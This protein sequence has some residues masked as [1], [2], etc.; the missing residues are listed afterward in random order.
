MTSITKIIKTLHRNRTKRGGLDYLLGLLNYSGYWS[1]FSSSSPKVLDCVCV[2]NVRPND[3]MISSKTMRHTCSYQ[4]TKRCYILYYYCVIFSRGIVCAWNVLLRENRKQKTKLFPHIQR[5]S[6]IEATKTSVKITVRTLTSIWSP[7]LPLQS[8][9]Q[10]SCLCVHGFTGFTFLSLTT[11]RNARCVFPCLDKANIWFPDNAHSF[12]GK[13]PQTT[14][15]LT[16]SSS[17][18]QSNFSSYYRRR[19]RG[20]QLFLLKS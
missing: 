2:N 17:I 8:C 3:A 20:R 4:R 18:R 11:G 6:L 12:S 10:H 15:R 7:A 16:P 19:H 14:P 1:D 9:I 5:K 13:K